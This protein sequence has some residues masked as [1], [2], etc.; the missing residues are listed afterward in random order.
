MVSLASNLVPRISPLWGFRTVSNRS[1]A[2]REFSF[3]YSSVVQNLHWL[4]TSARIQYKRA[5]FQ[6][7][8]CIGLSPTNAGF[9]HLDCSARFSAVTRTIFRSVHIKKKKKKKNYCQRCFYT[10]SRLHSGAI[11]RCKKSFFF[12]SVVRVCMYVC[13]YVCVCVCMC[14]CVC[15]CVC[16]RARVRE[17]GGDCVSVC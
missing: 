7:C 1:Q 10:L 4:P 14:V 2:V 15:V 12:K 5:T 8:E 11:K 3:M 6:H 13:M 17:G 9:I 16:V